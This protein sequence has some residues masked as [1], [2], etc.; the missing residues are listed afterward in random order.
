MPARRK[1]TRLAERTPEAD[2][3][4]GRR[5]KEL[6]EQRSMNQGEL[7]EAMG[8]DRSVV[9]LIEDGER[10]LTAKD[11]ASASSALVVRIGALLEG[12]ISSGSIAVGG[13]DEDAIA[14]LRV[15]NDCID[16]YRGIEALARGGSS[17][18]LRFGL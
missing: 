5:I 10:P 9:L 11:L 4:L 15:F 16:E 6:R 1:V 12:D 14:A 13:S 2:Q 18:A 17:S 3:A 8:V 7:A